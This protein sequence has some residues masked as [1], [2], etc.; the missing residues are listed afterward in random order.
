MGFGQKISAIRSKFKN[1]LPGKLLHFAN[2]L[3][4]TSLYLICPFMVLTPLFLPMLGAAAYLHYRY[5]KDIQARDNSYG[6][7]SVQPA[8]ATNGPGVQ[9]S[10]NLPPPGIGPASQFTDPNYSEVFNPLG[11]PPQNPQQQTKQPPQPTRQPP[12]PATAGLGHP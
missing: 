8:T 9:P 7:P 5:I 2:W 12:Q 10:R 11:A 1:S 3:T 4:F 6:G